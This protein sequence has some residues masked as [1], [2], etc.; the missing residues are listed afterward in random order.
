MKTKRIK[1][2]ID[3]LIVKTGITPKSYRLGIVYPSKSTKLTTFKGNVT[4]K[5]FQIGVYYTSHS[6]TEESFVIVN[7]FHKENNIV[8]GKFVPIIKQEGVEK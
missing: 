1:S 6:N 3:E 8:Y 2:E 4:Y 7:P 5:N